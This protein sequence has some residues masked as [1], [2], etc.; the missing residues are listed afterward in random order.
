METSEEKVV[1]VLDGLASPGAKR[2]YDTDWNRFS[3]WIAGQRIGP[4]EVTPKVVRDHVL[5]MRDDR[6]LARATIGKAI[7]VIREVYRALVNDEVIAVNPARETKPPKMDRSIK[8]PVLTE[9]QVRTLLAA[10]PTATWKD[11]RNLLVLKSLLGLGWRR[12]EIG[13]MRGSDIDDQ[14]ISAIVKGGKRIAVAMPAWLRAEINDWRGS[15][16]G[17]IFP[18]KPGGDE[19]ITGNIIYDIVD[20]AGKRVGMKRG[21]ISP[22]AWRRTYITLSGERGVSLKDRQMAV[23]HENQATT[24]RYDHARAARDKAVGDV[25]AGIVNGDD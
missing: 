25:F 23:G 1:A 5:W 15:A 24:E 7:S 3:E 18:R 4:L 12:A 16:T 19:E 9:E 20:K 21:T 2:A 8:T 17:P 14:V 22:H 10:Q 13:R 6:K 11:A